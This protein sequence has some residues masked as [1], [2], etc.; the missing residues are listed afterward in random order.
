[1]LSTWFRASTGA[2]KIHSASLTRRWPVRVTGLEKP[3]RCRQG[4]RSGR[5]ADSRARRMTQTFTKEK[6]NGRSSLPVLDLTLAIGGMF[7][8]LWVSGAT[9]QKAP[10]STCLP[11]TG[12]WHVSTG[13][14]RDTR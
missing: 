5:N 1:M 7:E 11:R 3:C 6:R 12:H 14:A 9:S 2:P 10:R 13:Y 4:P 8:R